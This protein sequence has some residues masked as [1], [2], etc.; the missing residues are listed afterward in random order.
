MK[1]YNLKFVR[2][3][4][5]GAFLRILNASNTATENSILSYYEHIQQY[6]RPNERLFTEF[7]LNS[8]LR[9]S[10]AIESFN[11]IIKLNIEGRISDYYN[12]EWQCLQHFKYPKLF[13]RGT[14]NTYLTFLRKEFLMRIADSQ[15]LTYNQIR[16]RLERKGIKMRL[17]EFRDWYGT[18]LISNGVLEAEQNL[19]CG[20]IPVSIFIRHYWS[21]NSG[22]WGKGFLGA[23]SS[24]LSPA[25]PTVHRP[26]EAI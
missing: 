14:K 9:T 18:T 26:V 15:P 10:E 1:A 16:K 19:V 23:I 3:N 17:N 12:E 8:G 13:I 11:L 6:L 7:L 4:S 2:P 22:N 21:L 20:R 25:H 24:A 5:L